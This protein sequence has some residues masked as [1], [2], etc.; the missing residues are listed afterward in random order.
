[1]TMARFHLYRY[2]LLPKNRHFQGDLYGAKSVEDLIAQKNFIFQ[3]VLDSEA[4]F[5]SDRSEIAIR[6]LFS[7]DGFTLFRLATSRSL[8]IETKDFSTKSVS[9]WPNI[10][11]AV[12]NRD[13]KQIIA[14]QKR[15]SAFQITSAV[16]RMLLAAA[17]PTLSIHQLT[18]IWEPMFERQ[19][20]W[21]MIGNYANRVK[22]VEFEI[23][24]PNMANIS[25]TLPDELKALAKNTN[26]VRS[27]V[28]LESDPGYA[29]NLD[30]EDPVLNGLTTY[31]SE[32]GGNIS[33]K[34]GG[35][36]KKIHTTDTVKEVEIDEAEITGDARIVASI[37]KE[38]MN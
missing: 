1:M 10:L 29:L 31:A 2:Q 36:K 22:K 6:R 4:P 3:S 13:D 30:P 14:V 20:F 34:I 11:V 21:S 23:I 5:K 7:E 37:L 32:G 16:V 17:E 15:Y 35:L 33:V 25:K 19:A 8:S 24:T 26:A 28:E 12:W 38:L 27:K 9:N 18:V